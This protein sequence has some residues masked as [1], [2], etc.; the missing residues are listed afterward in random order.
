MS[1]TGGHICPCNTANA[2]GRGFF[3]DDKG[4]RTVPGRM[5]ASGKT[6]EARFKRTRFHKQQQE[7]D[8][9]NRYFWLSREGVI[10]ICTCKCSKEER[11]AGKRGAMRLLESF[12]APKNGE[13]GKI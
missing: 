6:L 5:L 3:F 1:T 4:G 2:L 10:H 13:I 9:S 8:V 12:A 7:L 11:E